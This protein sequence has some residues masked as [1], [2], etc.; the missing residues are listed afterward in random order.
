MH[1]PRHARGGAASGL[2]KLLAIIAIA[3]IVFG[4]GS[5]CAQQAPE[6]AGRAAA[7]VTNGVIDAA[8]TAASS[9][10][11][12]NVT[13]PLKRT[14]NNLI[15]GLFGAGRDARDFWDALSPSE[16]FD[17][18]C[19]NLPVSGVDKL[20][21]Y[22][23]A[24][25]AAATDAQVERIA[26]LW[27]SAG[28]S[29]NGTALVQKL[30]NTCVVHKNDPSALESCLA[31]GI[32][33]GDRS[34]CLA[35]APGQFFKQAAASMKPF[36]CPEN[37]PGTA[38][39]CQKPSAQSAQAAAGGGPR[40]DQPYIDCLAGAYNDQ[41]AGSLPYQRSCIDNPMQ[42]P[43]WVQCVEGQLRARLPKSGDWYI[44]NCGKVR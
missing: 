40:T 2:I 14:W 22:F 7:Q 32:E 36:A 8:G 15:D 17:A 13:G 16:K 10:W 28:T 29:P 5:Q 18:I 27:Q 1:T 38:A 42:P 33:P 4:K 20:C 25:L 44:Q 41:V 24:P 11:E 26:C 3:S 30:M 39:S 35:S 21:P 19:Q 34:Q 6:L 9:V 12:R 31:V 37:V 23:S 43:Q